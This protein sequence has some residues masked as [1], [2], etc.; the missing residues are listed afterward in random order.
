MSCLLIL[1]R[2]SHVLL[3]KQAVILAINQVALI[4]AK[5]M[6]ILPFSLLQ[7]YSS[8]PRFISLAFFSNY[9]LMALIKPLFY[10]KE[11]TGQHLGEI[12]IFKL[13]ILLGK[14]GLS[15]ERRSI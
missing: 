1:G 9:F 4:Y 14:C 3:S 5:S 10:F 2:K 7:K 13:H 8:L 6:G 12:L 15:H 11:R